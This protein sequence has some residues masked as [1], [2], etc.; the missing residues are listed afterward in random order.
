MISRETTA[1]FTGH[2]PDKLLRRI[3]KGHLPALQLELHNRIVTA[4]DDGYTRFLCGMAQGVDLWAGEMV[5]GLRQQFPQLELVSVIPFRAQIEHWS[6][7]WQLRY[8]WV[9]EQADDV[10]ITSNQIDRSAYFI[11]NRYLVDHASRLIG[12][13]DASIGGGTGYTVNYAKKQQI[14]L[15]LIPLS[16]LR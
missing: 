13:Y 12:V 6:R 4:V 8:Q 14:Q 11:R 2:R 5:L 9:L 1:C 7:D 16:C 10:I 3:T 15:D